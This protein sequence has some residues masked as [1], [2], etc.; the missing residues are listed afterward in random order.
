MEKVNIAEKFRVFDKYW[1]SKVVSDFNGQ[2]IKLS[3]LKGEFDWHYHKGEDEL[4]LVLKG[5]MII[6]FRGKEVSL[7]EGDLFIVPGDVEHRL[8]AREE[9]HI[10]MIDP[11]STSNSERTEKDMTAP[12]QTGDVTVE[13]SG[14]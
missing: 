12:F 7:N 10:L 14:A 3:K 13:E 9:A 1:Q 4:Y 5:Q 6:Q 2:S 8:I 11:R